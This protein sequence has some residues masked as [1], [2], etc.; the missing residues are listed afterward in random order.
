MPQSV[1]WGPL[2]CHRPQQNQKLPSR[3]PL[4]CPPH[5]CCLLHDLL[6]TSPWQQ[7]WLVFLLLFSCFHMARLN[8]REAS[9]LRKYLTAKEAMV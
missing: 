2:E 6:P 7:L 9:Q 8:F 1:L 3:R 5:P 4:G